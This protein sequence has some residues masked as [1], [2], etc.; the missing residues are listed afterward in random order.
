M[1]WN[2]CPKVLPNKHSEVFMGFL[3][4]F[5]H[6]DNMQEFIGGQLVYKSWSITAFGA[7]LSGNNT[8]HVDGRRI[9]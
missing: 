5:C 3:N 2:I 9:K 4:Y 7:Y 1:L 6:A 8:H